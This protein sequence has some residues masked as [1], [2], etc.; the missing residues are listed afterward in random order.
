MTT[1]Y[2]GSYNGFQWS[3]G[4][5]TTPEWYASIR[6]LAG[7]VG[8]RVDIPVAERTGHGAQT[9][10]PRYPSK[11]V[12]VG[13][14]IHGGTPEGLQAGIL[15][16]ERAFTPSG[17]VLPLTVGDWAMWV[18][19]EDCQP[20]TDPE[21]PKTEINTT[22]D[23]TFLAADPFAYSA[24]AIDTDLPTG[25][26]SRTIDLDNVGSKPGRVGSRA[27]T[28]SINAAGTNVVRPYVEISGRRTTVD[29]TLLNGATLYIDEG[30]RVRVGSQYLDGRTRGNGLAGTMGSPAA[31]W[32][33]IPVGESELVIGAASGLM[34]VQVH[35]RSVR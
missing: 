13:L 26:T 18:Q 12:T 1:P 30:Y 31:R 32:P 25:A 10:Q 8:H 4:E 35:H 22:V 20:V 16:V 27:C 19:V 3:T 17:A 6:T 33:I 34:A 11:T 9:G 23:V 7:F 15:A 5:R 29:Y 24:V 21:H 14:T 28:V 2:A